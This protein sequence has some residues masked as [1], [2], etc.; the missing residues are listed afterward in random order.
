MAF[1]DRDKEI[2]ELTTEQLLELIPHARKRPL[3][4]QVVIG[5]ELL[6]RKVKIV[7]FVKRFETMVRSLSTQDL[8]YIDR[9]DYVFS[10]ACI[11]GAAHELVKRSVKKLNWFCLTD[12]IQHGPFSRL[13]FETAIDEGKVRPNDLVWK[14]SEPKWLKF[15]DCR[16]MSDDYFFDEELVDFPETIN[17]A[18]GSGL[19]SSSDPSLMIVG[20]VF[21]LLTFPFWLVAI[22]IVPFASFSSST[23]FILPV[24]LAM[25]ACILS[26]PVG[27]GLILKQKWAYGF[28]V[29]SGVILIAWLLSRILIDGGSKLWMLYVLAEV[30]ILVLVISGRDIFNTNQYDSTT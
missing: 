28:K 5:D 20:G 11:R 10:R 3:T 17:Q 23:G 13:Q 22:F 27:I 30:I 14:E 18:P 2:R 26:I 24:I 6:L 21:E 29:G 1:R 9:F 4:A 19:A 7:G 25:G 16:C 12:G 8:R 15:K